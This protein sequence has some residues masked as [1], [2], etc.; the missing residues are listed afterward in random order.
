MNPRPKYSSFSGLKCKFIKWLTCKGE[1]CK[2]ESST[3]QSG[4]NK[5]RTKQNLHLFIY[6]GL[7]FMWCFHELPYFGLFLQMVRN[8]EVP[9]SVIK[10]TT[11]ILTAQPT[12]HKDSFIECGEICTM[13]CL[14]TFYNQ[15]N[16]KYFSTHFTHMN[17]WLSPAPMPS[18][19]LSRHHGCQLY[20]IWLRVGVQERD[21]TAV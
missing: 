6:K 16:A 10:R 8:I 15:V 17:V 2:R 11:T 9:E 1:I 13:G 21:G 3:E 19:N 5:N 4:T 20:H 18:I 14:K 12:C 7:A